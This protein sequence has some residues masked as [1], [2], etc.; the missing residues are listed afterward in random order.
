MQI[1]N[2]A[3]VSVATSATVI[4]AAATAKIATTEGMDAIA[5]NPSVDIALVDA[6]GAGAIAAGTAAGTNF[7]AVIPGAVAGT[8]A[9]SPLVC[10]A[11]VTTIVTHRSGAVVG[12]S[13]SGTATVKVAVCAVP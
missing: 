7:N 11:N 2:L 5:I 12:I 4:F 9:N 3:T 8:V 10:P 6:S 13:T 1:V